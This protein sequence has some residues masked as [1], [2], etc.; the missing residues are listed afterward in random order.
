MEGRSTM[1]GTSFNYV[2]LR[3]L[4]QEA[5]GGDGAMLKARKWILDHGGATA[6]S[7]WGKIVLSVGD[8]IFNFIKAILVT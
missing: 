7:A 3:L 2:C 6:T 4:G 8:E 5:E 1:L